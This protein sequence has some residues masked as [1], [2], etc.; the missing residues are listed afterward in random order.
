MKLD[1][2]TLLIS[3]ANL[4]VYWIKTTKD[5]SRKYSARNVKFIQQIFLVNKALMVTIKVL[6]QL[7]FLYTNDTK[8]H[9]NK[10]KFV[11]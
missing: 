6:T 3:N 11:I 5:V 10:P 8:T 1:T 4:Y 7:S 9:F 2:R